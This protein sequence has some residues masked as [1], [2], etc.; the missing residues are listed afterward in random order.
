MTNPGERMS[1]ED[2]AHCRSSGTETGGGGV[3]HKLIV[4]SAEM[5]AAQFRAQSSHLSVKTFQ[6]TV[7]FLPFSLVL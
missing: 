3:G 5:W 7:V 6:L 4:D 1:V 2:G